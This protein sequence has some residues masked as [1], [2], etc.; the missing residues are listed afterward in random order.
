MGGGGGAEKR[1]GDARTT[2]EPIYKAILCVLNN[3]FSKIYKT[4]QVMVQVAG[5]GGGG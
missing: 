3:Y 4:P 5:G 2:N 1:A